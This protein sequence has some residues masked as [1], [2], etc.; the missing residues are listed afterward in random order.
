MPLC[1]RCQRANPE[2]AAFCSGCGAPLARLETKIALEEIA[3]RVRRL[4]L[5]EQPLAYEP[6]FILRGLAQLTLR[7]SCPMTPSMP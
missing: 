5:P 7:I 6:S 3:T 1:P 2:D 4:E